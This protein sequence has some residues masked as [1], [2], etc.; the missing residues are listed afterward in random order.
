MACIACFLS[1]ILLGDR[2]AGYDAEFSRENSNSMESTDLNVLIY[3][4]FWSCQKLKLFRKAQA[5]KE[6]TQYSKWFLFYMVSFESPTHWTQLSTPCTQVRSKNI[7][8]YIS[9]PYFQF[10]L[11]SKGIIITFIK[12][13]NAFQSV[14]YISYS[15]KLESSVRSC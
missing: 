11:T 10:M 8:F 9:S 6:F 15:E 12:S 13:F 7:V 5:L 3:S 1:S 4:K 2:A 14:K